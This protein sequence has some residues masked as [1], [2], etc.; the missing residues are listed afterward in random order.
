M[1]KPDPASKDIEES[2][3]AKN[4]PEFDRDEVRRFAEFLGR[5][6]DHR[7]GKKLPPSPPGMLAWLGGCE[8]K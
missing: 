3:E 5:L 2:M 7:A 4:I 1:W 6:R 8:Q